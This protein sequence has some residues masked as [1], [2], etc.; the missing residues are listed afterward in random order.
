MITASGSLS[1]WIGHRAGCLCPICG[2][3][4]RA[5]LTPKE[6]MSGL[7]LPGVIPEDEHAIEVVDR[8]ELLLWFRGLE[9]GEYSMLNPNRALLFRVRPDPNPDS[10]GADEEED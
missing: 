6:M 1:C 4:P 3:R 5:V 9:G 2:L 7:I 10:W 8:L